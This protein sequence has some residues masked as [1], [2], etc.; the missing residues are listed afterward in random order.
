KDRRIQLFLQIFYLLV[1]IYT[2]IN[3]FGAMYS[4]RYPGDIFE[5]H[6]NNIPAFSL[7]TGFITGFTALISSFTLWTRVNWAF[8]FATFTSGLL[9]SYNLTEIGGAIYRN[10]Y[11]SVPMV[12]ILVVVLQS[13]PFLL[14]QTDR[15][16]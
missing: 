6:N 8:G 12:I 1:G 15:H 5:V 10:P 14:K 11:E 16:L 13:F 9:F 2:I 7:A 3:S 4:N